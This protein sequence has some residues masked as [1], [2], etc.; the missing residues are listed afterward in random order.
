MLRNMG[1]LFAVVL[2][3]DV[4]LACFWL[5]SNIADVIR[6]N[7]DAELVPLWVRKSLPEAEF[8]RLWS[9]AE[10][11]SARIIDQAIREDFPADPDDE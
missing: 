1:R 5:A 2:R 4:A 6:K 10:S 3:F 9:Q 7:T 8:E 11:Q